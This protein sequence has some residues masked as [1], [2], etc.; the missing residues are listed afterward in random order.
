MKKKNA[1]SLIVLVITILVMAILATT[2]IIT[3]SNT[4]IITKSQ[5]TVDKYNM[6]QLKESIETS[7]LELYAKNR[8]KDVDIFTFINYLKNENIIT[9]EQKTELLHNSGRIGTGKNALQLDTGLIIKYEGATVS[10]TDGKYKISFKYELD[11]LD[12]IE[13]TS[14]GAVF[15]PDFMIPSEYSDIPLEE[16]I[17]IQDS[18]NLSVVDLQVKNYVDKD[19]K[20]AFNVSLTSIPSSNLGTTLYCRPYV[21]CMI[22]GEEIVMHMPINS[23]VIELGN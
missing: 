1:I 18:Y 13:Y 6:Q 23:A 11:I 2:A 14:F 15:L 19:G 5:E 7:R 17:T 8:G 4:N 9:D 16:L 10:E 20:Y 12:D 22:D 3:L 21:K